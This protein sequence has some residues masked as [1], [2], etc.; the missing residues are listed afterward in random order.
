MSLGAA[1]IS[2]LL[3]GAE[4]SSAETGDIYSP[5]TLPKKELGA[6]EEKELCSQ[7]YGGNVLEDI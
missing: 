2:G 1:P 5:V 3:L 4:S 6:D 7:R